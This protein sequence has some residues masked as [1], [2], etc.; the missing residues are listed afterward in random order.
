MT[1]NEGLALQKTIRQRVASLEKLRGEVSAERHYFGST[2][3]VETPKYDVKLVDKK[4]TSLESF[5]FKLD[6]AIKRANAVTE[7]T[8]DKVDVD[9]L[10]APLE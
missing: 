4:I 10:L 5:L 3:K 1:I 7:L 8:L 6:A 2:E 9:Q